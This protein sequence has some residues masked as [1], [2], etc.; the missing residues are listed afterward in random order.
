MM[1]R[2]EYLDKA[3]VDDGHIDPDYQEY[4]NDDDEY[5]AWLD[6]INNGAEDD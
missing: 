6:K 3:A 2:D 4:L 5:L 1:T